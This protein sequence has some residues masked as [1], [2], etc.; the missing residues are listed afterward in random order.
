VENGE[1][2]MATEVEKVKVVPVPVVKGSGP[3]VLFQSE[4]AAKPPKVEEEGE[5]KPAAVGEV[6]KKPVVRTL[7]MHEMVM[8]TPRQTIPR[9]IIGKTWYSFQANKK[10]TV[11]R[12]VAMVLE[13]KGVV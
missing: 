7:D 3:K 9:T 10:C 1:T 12:Y 11:P 5:P 4:E 13:E 8:V 6:E 2:N